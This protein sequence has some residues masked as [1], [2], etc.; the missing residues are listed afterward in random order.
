VTGT[1]DTQSDRITALTV[2][3]STLRVRGVVDDLRI[4]AP[5]VSAK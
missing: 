5:A 2:T 4:A 1:V 3:R